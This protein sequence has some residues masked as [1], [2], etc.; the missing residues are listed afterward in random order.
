MGIDGRF[1][2]VKVG[3]IMSE[4]LEEG[5]IVESPE[6]GIFEDAEGL[7]CISADTEELS[8]Y[9]IHGVVFNC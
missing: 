7:Y 3:P 5:K 6:I 2:L 4:L 1:K 9:I 8:S